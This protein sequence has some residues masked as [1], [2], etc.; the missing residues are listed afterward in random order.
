[1]QTLY[2]LSRESEIDITIVTSPIGSV[3][4]WGAAGWLENPNI[5]KHSVDKHAGANEAR[6]RNRNG[7]IGAGDAVVWRIFLATSLRVE[8]YE[9]R[10][11]H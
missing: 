8:N 1:M 7:V 9:R 10:K 4:F 3:V 5:R 6:V 2:N 11:E